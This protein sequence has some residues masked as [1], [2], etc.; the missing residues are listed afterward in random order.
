[1][2]VTVIDGDRACEVV[3]GVCYLLVEY[4][5]LRRVV[6]TVDAVREQV[7]PCIPVQKDIE[8]PRRQVKTIREYDDTERCV[9]LGEVVVSCSG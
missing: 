6:E 9:F 3:P 1:V 7:G 4:H 2:V 8:K 5:R